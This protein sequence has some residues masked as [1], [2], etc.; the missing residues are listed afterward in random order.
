MRLHFQEH[1]YDNRRCDINIG[2]FRYLLLTGVKQFDT[3]HITNGICIDIGSEKRFR[4]ACNRIKAHFLVFHS[5]LMAEVYG[6]ETS[7]Y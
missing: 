7:L 4:S 5:D 3:Y 6:H 1:K 2:K